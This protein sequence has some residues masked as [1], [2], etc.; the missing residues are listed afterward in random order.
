MK[1]NLLVYLLLVSSLPI[2]TLYGKEESSSAHGYEKNLYA[3][4]MLCRTGDK[5]EDALLFSGNANKPLAEKI[6]AYL[7]MPLG[8]ATV[9][10]FNDGEISI[11]VHDNIRKRD[12]YII[13]STCPSEQSVN[14]NLMELFL[15]VRAMKRSSARSITAVIP[16]YG[17]ARQDRKTSSRVPISA[18]DI[19]YMLEKA[20]VDRVVTVDLHCGQIQGF[21]TQV[22]VDN[23][24]AA[25]LFTSYFVAK[26]LDNAV[27]V[28][29]DA[30]GVQRASKF[31]DNLAKYGVQAQMAMI[32]KQRAGA[33]I[34]NSMDLIGDVTNADAII[35][36]DICDTGGTLI[37]A[38]ELLKQQGAKRVFAV[39]THPVF[40][41]NALE[42]IGKSVIDEMVVADT[43]PLQGLIPSN[44]TYLSVSSLLG[45]AIKRIQSGES[46]SALFE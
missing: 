4:S 45:E 34:I 36:D 1:K 41:C 33:G 37:K 24:Y 22:P 31:R 30:G 42:K 8:N 26:N 44:I 29:P 14:D 28:S 13:Q 43:I 20:G 40:S 19:A 10:K 16:Y 9:K 15:L 38:A 39:I 6:A 35:I 32:S 46:I 7:H 23:L 18:A 11:Q 21:F 17:Y 2:C 3:D 5:L 27:V 12:V 25:S